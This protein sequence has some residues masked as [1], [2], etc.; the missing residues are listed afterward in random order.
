MTRHDGGH[1][2][3]YWIHRK[4]EDPETG[5]DAGID[6]A[7]AFQTLAAGVTEPGE[8]AIE[9]ADED[10]AYRVSTLEDED[11]AD[12]VKRPARRVLSRARYHLRCRDLVGISAD[13]RIDLHLAVTI[14]E[15]ASDR[16][17]A[18]IIASAR[19]FTQAD[20]KI[21]FVASYDERA[22]WRGRERG[23][24]NDGTYAHVPWQSQDEQPDH[25]AHVSIVDP[26]YV[27]YTK[28]DEHGISDRQ[29]RVRPGRYLE[30]FY[31]HVD[32]ETRQQ[33]IASCSADALALKIATTADEIRKVYENGPNS[34][35]G[36]HRDGCDTPK[37]SSW[38]H[39]PAEV[40]AGPDLAVAYIGT[41]DRV[42][43]R[44]VVWPEEKTYSRTYG[45]TR[46]LEQV[47]ERAGYS[48]GDL[49]GAS[50]RKITHSNGQ[51]LMPYI[52]GI[53]GASVDGRFIVLDGDGPIAT[54]ETC[55]Y[56]SDA[57]SRC[58]DC[59]EMYDPDDDDAT[60]DYCAS[61]MEDRSTCESCGDCVRNDDTTYLEGTHVS[62]CDDCYR[63]QSRDCAIDGCGNSF[64]PD[65]FSRRERDR[66]ADRG[67]SDCCE[68]CGTSY[69]YCCEHDEYFSDD[70]T[71]TCSGCDENAREDED[72]DEDAPIVHVPAHVARPRAS[73]GMTSP[74]PLDGTALVNDTGWIFWRYN[75]DMLD[76][77]GTVWVWDGSASWYMEPED[78]Y[79][80]HPSQ[81]TPASM[82]CGNTFVRCADPRP[83][84]SSAANDG[85]CS[86][87]GQLLGDNGCITI[88][89]DIYEAA[90]VAF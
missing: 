9:R 80:L 24:F 57:R 13:E 54:Q 47:L 1:E 62:I 50:I 14:L 29:T 65:Q 45:S 88:G 68:D 43:A 51:Y 15:H 6:R 20:S 17:N 10:P 22:T 48:R 46:V 28:D 72:E 27:A 32:L 5:I 84:P 70:G 52:D 42:S 30:Q 67:T 2:M 35:M 90:N 38:T 55:G 81:F 23:R 59:G 63:Q 66:R 60:A 56:A 34:C 85:R 89:C 12:Y 74:L 41:L 71:D 64:H 73:D 36:G 21:T 4:D 87:C 40:Y 44:A 76:T 26:G 53:H 18:D 79:Q 77:R 83:I 11:C 33:W 86:T 7:V 25:Y 16:V 58:E 75:G 39:H 69:Q 61:C 82:D 49:T 3:P 31:S 37:F 19:R 78:A 8:R